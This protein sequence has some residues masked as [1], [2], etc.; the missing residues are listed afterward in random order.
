MSWLAKLGDGSSWIAS[1]WLSI[2]PSIKQD[3]IDT[4]LIEALDG[5]VAQAILCITENID[6]SDSLSD[7]AVITALTPGRG[8]CEKIPIRRLIDVCPTLPPLDISV[9]ILQ[10][11]LY[12]ATS[13]ESAIPGGDH[14]NRISDIGFPSAEDLGCR[15]HDVS[16]LSARLAEYPGHVESNHWGS[17]AIMRA[18][19][20]PTRAI[21][22]PVPVLMKAGVGVVVAAASTSSSSNAS[23]WSPT[24]LSASQQR[25]QQDQAAAL[26]AATIAVNQ[27]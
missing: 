25:D 1:Y 16:L 3:L 6:V 2:G 27:A 12:H 7:G 9:G 14:A 10:V 8:S 18:L 23:T 11:F 24:S 26:H 21:G 17:P 20:T 5:K 22:G 13:L 15:G 4:R 19:L